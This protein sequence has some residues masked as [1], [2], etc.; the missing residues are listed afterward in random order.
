VKDLL[1]EK[2]LQDMVFHGAYCDAKILLEAAESDP[3]SSDKH[4]QDVQR[5]VEELDEIRLKNIM[6]R[7]PI[8]TRY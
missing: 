2:I 7:V 3:K 8:V 6:Q 1:F 4:K 5:M